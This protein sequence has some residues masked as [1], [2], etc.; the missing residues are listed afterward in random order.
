MIMTEN[1]VYLKQI[2]KIWRDYTLRALDV[3]KYIKTICESHGMMCIA[4][5]SIS[6][7]ELKWELGIKFKTGYA[8]VSITVAESLY[9]DATD[10][11]INFMLEVVTDDALVLGGCSPYNYT[12]EVWIDPFNDEEVEERFRIFENE[13]DYESI[14]ESIIDE[15]NKRGVNV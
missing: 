14:I 15:N 2:E 4:P 10:K 11:G 9:Y 12:D 3:L 5:E 6:G 7:D 1:D 13:I 8:I